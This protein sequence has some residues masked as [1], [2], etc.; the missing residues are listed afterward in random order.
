MSVE[1]HAGKS[2]A[3][4]HKTTKG[5]T[6]AERVVWMTRTSDVVGSHMKTDLESY[7]TLIR[8]KI[9][10]KCATTMELITQIR[11][12]KIGESGHVTP[13]E[14][15]FTLIKFG[16]I[17]PQPLVDRIFNVFDSDRSGTMDF[18]EFAMWIMNSEFRPAF[19]T[20]KKE[21][22]DSPRTFLRKK[23]QACVTTHSK[24]FA[25]MKKQVS[26]LEFVSDINRKGMD[27]TEREARTVFQTL[28][29]R[30]TGF[31]ETAV[32]LR[33]AESGRL[34]AYTAPSA[35]KPSEIKAKSLDELVLKVIGRNSRQLESAFAHIQLGQ[36]VR[37]PFEEFRRALL[38]AGVGKNIHDSRQL[39]NALSGGSNLADI[40]LFFHSLSPMIID[41]STEVSLKIVPSS[42]IS[43]S[44]AD[45]HLR[46]AL[47]K[48]FKDV[49]SDIESADSSSSG[50]IEAE[51]LYRI[52]VKRCMPLTFQDFRFILQQV[53]I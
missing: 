37:I 33:W 45:R 35:D 51:T 47:R 15:R 16:I 22:I 8:R 4:A 7:L 28:D 39:F 34:E 3:D 44:R 18:D 40:D 12:N 1:V 21:E 46:D 49:K 10:E 36:G 2:A 42:N 9:Q 11:R 31:V 30:D 50:F 6:T 25:N 14:F 29:P 27:L 20:K 19:K 5:G 24:V 23:F 52:L 53:K 17:L 13:N 48:S 32:L 43:A 41:P 38:N 26:F